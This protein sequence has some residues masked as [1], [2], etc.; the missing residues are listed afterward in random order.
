MEMS[1]GRCGGA[2]RIKAEHLKSWLRG[3]PRDSCSKC[4]GWEDMAQV[5]WSLYVC[6]EDGNDSTTNALGNNSP[7]TKGGRGVPGDWA[8]GTNLEGDGEDH[9]SQTGDDCDA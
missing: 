7:D 9:G 3:G 1:F 2:S 5:C 8:D 4:R 6:L